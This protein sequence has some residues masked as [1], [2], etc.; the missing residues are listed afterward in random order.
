MNTD[1]ADI[2]A[3][4]VAAE[5]HDV[6]LRL[7]FADKIQEGGETALAEALRGPNGVEIVETARGICA[8]IARPIDAAAY[9][10]AYI[11][12][13]PLSRK[14]EEHKAA[15]ERKRAET[16]RRVFGPLFNV[17]GSALLT[18][19]DGPTCTNCRMIGRVLSDCPL[20]HG[21]GEPK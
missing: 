16:I 6:T 3:K 9:A 5:P 8:T 12:W 1:D 13:I 11:F 14:A 15:A 4:L 10:F 17:S 20:C 18:N 7:V 19:H 2:L 21:T